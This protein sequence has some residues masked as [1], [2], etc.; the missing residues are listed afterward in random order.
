MTDLTPQQV[1]D[2][3]LPNDD[4][5]TLTVRSYLIA[6]LMKVWREGADFNGR[7]PFGYSGWRYDVYAPMIRAGMV[8]GSFDNFGYV[9]DCDTVMAERLI[10]AAIQA[11]GA[12]AAAP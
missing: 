12:A 2:L 10:L 9:E 5:G 4:S 11:L 7:R 8:R 1:L 6:L 3:P